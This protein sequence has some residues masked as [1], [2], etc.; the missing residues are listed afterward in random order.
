MIITISLR[1]FGSR[2][3]VE[4]LISKGK[5]T[6][7]GKKVLQNIQVS[8]DDSIL[9]DGKPVEI[10]PTK[11]FLHNKKRGVLVTHAKDRDGKLILFEQLKRMGIQE[12]LIS[13]G[14]FN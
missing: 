3:G 8:L 4:D 12:R 2:R 10:P 9:V 13:V 6:V 11:V 7:N 1:Q 5:V 14:R